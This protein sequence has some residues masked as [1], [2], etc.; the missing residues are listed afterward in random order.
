MAIKPKSS[1]IWPTTHWSQVGRLGNEG[2]EERCQA[3][4]SLVRT[5]LP[6]LRRHL[7]YRRHIDPGDV[8]DLLQEFLLSKIV[9]LQILQSAQEKR[10]RFRT[11]LATALDRFALNYFR[12]Q[13]S[14]KRASIRFR[15][16]EDA[17]QVIADDH[18]STDLFDVAWARQ[19]LGRAIRQL[20]AECFRW[21][22]VEIWEV[23]RS[24]ILNP[25]LHG[26]E[27]APLKHLVEKLGLESTRKVSNLLREANR[28][29]G[30][31]VQRVIGT[32]DCEEAEI[33]SEIRDL[34][35]ILSRGMRKTR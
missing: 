13:N 33:Q 19:V 30:Q 12:G 32:Y 23:F 7:L 20:R 28:M 21:N 14:Q 3:L 34:R 25:A 31:S 27:P 26:G 18:R 22:Q 15:S 6:V 2:I 16:L 24:Q 8:D 17:G 1:Q 29:F 9:K 11:F 10:G 5:Y 35:R 4:E